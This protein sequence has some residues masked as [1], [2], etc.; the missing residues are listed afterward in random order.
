V[1]KQH[2]QG[3]VEVDGFDVTADAAERLAIKER[4]RAMGCPF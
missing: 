3:W 2:A 1:I 4:A